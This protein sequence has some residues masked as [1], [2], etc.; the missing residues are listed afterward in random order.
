MT[1]SLDSGLNHRSNSGSSSNSSSLLK[2]LPRAHC[3]FEALLQVVN[4]EFHAGEHSVPSPSPSCD[5]IGLSMD[6]SGI[7]TNELNTVAEEVHAGSPTGYTPYAYPPSLPS[8]S[9]QPP[10]LLNFIFP[11]PLETVVQA[12]NPPAPTQG[13]GIFPLPGM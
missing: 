8:P 10:H 4:R 5:D 3:S 1:H 12:Q 6:S 7:S 9:R 2:N 13:T 11:R